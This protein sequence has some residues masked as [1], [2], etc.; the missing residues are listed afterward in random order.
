MTRTLYQPIEFVLAYM[1]IFKKMWDAY[2][3]HECHTTKCT[4]DP[5][6]WYSHTMNSSN[7]YFHMV[8]RIKG[9]FNGTTILMHKGIMNSI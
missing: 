1:N 6:K 5:I 3:W 7:M 9:I 2:L 4:Y 8:K